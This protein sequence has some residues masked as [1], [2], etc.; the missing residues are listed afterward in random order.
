MFHL[1]K[2]RAGQPIAVTNGRFHYTRF[3][4]VVAEPVHKPEETRTF[5]G[6]SPIPRSLPAPQTTVPMP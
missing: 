6:Q 2:A 5:H 3:L 4:V 1:T